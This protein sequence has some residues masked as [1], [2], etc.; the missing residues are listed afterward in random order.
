M[1]L[2]RGYAAIDFSRVAALAYD[3]FAEKKLDL[4]KSETVA[5]LE[6]F[7]TERLRGLLA[8]ATS[9]SVA[10]AV[11]AGSGPAS[12]H[13]VVAAMARARALQ[14]V[15]DRNEPW[16]DKA[17]T[18][19]KRLAGISREAQPT[20]HEPSAFAGSRKKDDVV[21]Q[22]LVRDLH[23]IAAGLTSE[24][25]MRAALLEMGRFATEL[26]RVFVETLVNDPADDLTKTRLET[27]AHGAQSML[28][29]A[30]F[31]KLG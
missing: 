14:S 15:V 2:D 9:H 25:A 31:S 6:E 17:K 30:D 4:N 24:Q 11:L 7:A 28:K 5:R 12:L 27:L 23:E 26:D 22:K 18:V 10:D 20:L 29:I 19:A 21:I 16:L 8:N 3:G 1:L 13:N